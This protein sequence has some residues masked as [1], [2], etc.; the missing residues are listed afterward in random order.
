MTRGTC[1]RG[2]CNWDLFHGTTVLIH[3][4]TPSSKGKSSYT[5]QASAST[6][7]VLQSCKYQKKKQLKSR[8]GANSTG[9]LR[10]MALP[11]PRD[12]PISVRRTGQVRPE[13]G[14]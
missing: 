3:T 6:T 13:L 1:N 11:R 4:L 2:S 7:R 10:L 14:W 12:N 5:G 8:D 9:G